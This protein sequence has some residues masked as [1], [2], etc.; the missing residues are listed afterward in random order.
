M[1]TPVTA[2]V[3]ALAVSAA[4]HAH[5]VFAIPDDSGGKIHVIINEELKPS[6][7][8]GVG[9]I[10][11]TKLS[12][13]DAAG[14]ET[15]LTLTTEEHTLTGTLP[16]PRTGTRI[17]HGLTDLG[18]TSRGSSTPYRLLYYP[19]TI[20][21]SAFDA[22]LG[23]DVPVELVPHGKAGAVTL[24]LVARGKPLPDAEITVILPDGTQQKV[25]TGADGR[26]GPFKQ[27]GRYG[28]WARF[29][30][31]SERH[32]AT[33]VFDA[34]NTL[35]QPVASFGAIASGGWLYVYGGHIANTHKYHREAVSGRFDRMRID[36]PLAWEPLPA[37]P[38]MQGMNLA[39][40]DGK[41]YR[42]GGMVP[43]NL[44]NEPADNYSVAD[45][46]RFDPATNTWEALPPLP[47]PRSSH[48]VIVIGNQ[49]IVV[50][51]WT[52]QGKDG[53]TWADTLAVLDLNEKPLQWQTRQQPFQ[54]R[55]LVAAVH[56][57]KM[58]VIGGIDSKG[59][60]VQAVSV[61]NPRLDAWVDG[62]AV[63]GFAFAPA[64]GEHRGVLYASVADG[65]L[66]RLNEASRAWEKAGTT[67][68]RLSHRLVSN[69]QAV[70]IVGGATGGR[71]LD[72]IE[73][74]EPR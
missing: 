45:C 14:A 16:G 35:A 62:P 31:T 26:T 54:R 21:G 73:A 25:M 30:E 48:D 7:E 56:D 11:G 66:L 67:T 13:R 71:N 44:A 17:V 58:Y 20:L 29:W 39:A 49:L 65:S 47:A 1:R 60:V 12:L 6:L 43:R 42:I 37:G 51:G 59:N 70:L 27:T 15:P 23:G 55:A 3:L 36:G 4:L 68:P 63:P 64:A 61:Y 33:L 72:L 24:E 50:G 53:N 41:I 38:A 18:M 40:H 69:G 5:F 8:V 22:S 2:A 74:V 28:A 9:I 52:M 19:K 34:P 46:A 57:G 32:Y 10:A